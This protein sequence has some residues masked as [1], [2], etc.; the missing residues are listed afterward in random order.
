MDLFRTKKYKI[1]ANIGNRLYEENEYYPNYVNKNKDKM[2]NWEMDSLGLVKGGKLLLLASGYDKNAPKEARR[3][4]MPIMIEQGGTLMPT[5]MV[6]DPYWRKPQLGDYGEAIVEHDPI[7][8]VRGPPRQKYTAKGVKINRKTQS[9]ECM[10]EGRTLINYDEARYLQEIL[11]NNDLKLLAVQWK[12]L[13]TTQVFSIR[14]TIM[15]EVKDGEI[16]SGKGEVHKGEA[17]ID[18]MEVL[19]CHTLSM[20]AWE[21]FVLILTTSYEQYSS[22]EDEIEDFER[23]GQRFLEGQNAFSV[24]VHVDMSVVNLY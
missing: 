9:D 2:D 16:K 10:R 12:R 3:S 14:N 22:N 7:E 4:T 5:N 23:T 15:H 17:K 21:R 8:I 13:S 18:I 1:A 6:V 24:P 11:D 20:P 19:R